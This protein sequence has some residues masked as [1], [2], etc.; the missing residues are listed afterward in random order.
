PVEVDA[1]SAPPAEHPLG[2][3]DGE[4]RGTQEVRRQP[5]EDVRR[6][7]ELEQRAVL[8]GARL[9]VGVQT[10]WRPE[11]A[12]PVRPPEDRGVLDAAGPQD[13]DADGLEQC[14][15][16]RR[17]G[18]VDDALPALEAERPVHDLLG[19]PV[20]V[21]CPAHL[22]LAGG[23]TEWMRIARTRGPYHPGP[24]AA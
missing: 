2:L 11:R 14:R 1:P 10:P 3:P 21:R 15:V 22:I 8:A 18:E 13:G 7:E 24:P 5:D 17:I 20:P 12:Q 6:V 19:E 4:R 23:G 16:D 9:A